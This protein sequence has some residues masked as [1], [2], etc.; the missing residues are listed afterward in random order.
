MK[1]TVSQLRQ[2]IREEIGRRKR[3]ADDDEHSDPVA[4][5]GYPETMWVVVFDLPS[6]ISKSDAEEFC[7]SLTEKT[8]GVAS[9]V[10]PRYSSIY[11]ASYDVGLITRD[12]KK[13]DVVAKKVSREIDKSKLLSWDE[14][15]RPAPG[16]GAHVVGIDTKDPLVK[17]LLK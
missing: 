12:K 16:S 2:I 17:K 1:I 14:Q 6:S 7:D 3:G 5:F 15:E 13:A 10:L 8:N 11:K 9:R 4:D